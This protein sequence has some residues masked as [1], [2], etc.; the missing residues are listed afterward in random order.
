MITPAVR[1]RLIA[2]ALLAALTAMVWSSARAADD[3]D[4]APKKVD[5]KEL[6]K[7]ID[8]LGDDDEAKRKQAEEKLLSF[9]EAAHDA[10]RKAAK[11]HADADVRLRATLLQKKIASGAFRELKKMTGHE[12]KVRYVAVSKDGKKALSCGEDKTV[13]LW[14]LTTGKEIKQLKGH[15]GFTWQVGF[16]KDEK[17]AVSSGGPDKTVRLWDLDK[18]EEIR[19]YTGFA[20]R[21]YG[22]AIS[23]DDKYV[24]G[25]EGGDGTEDEKATFDVYLFDKETGKVV[26][27]MKGHT[28]YVWRAVFSPDSKMVATAG[29]NDGTF[30]IWS[31][32]TGKELHV[33][34]KAHETGKEADDFAWVTG[35][36][37]S[38]DSKKLLTC[39]R[40]AKVK[41][42]D[43]EN[44]KLIKTFE[45]LKEDPEAVAFAPN[46]KRFL[47]TDG[48]S[49]VIFDVDSGKIIHRFEE[50]TEPVLAVAF[51]SS[52]RRALSAG[53]DMTVRLWSVPM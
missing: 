6:A 12:K 30:R 43:A 14:D 52:G 16:S 48:K 51:L 50:H 34:K 39:G 35:V 26:H 40:D 11:D 45:G 42:W 13:R 28:G 36:A 24:V 27:T 31:V 46:G 37:F 3:D 29:M 53:A 38:P 49:A 9:G 32:E 33:G 44:G 10:V 25:G 4:D 5:A 22:A 15:T 7:W 47:T 41:L 21:V 19:Q 17:Q 23:P 20:K 18:G 8:Q 1:M 2:L